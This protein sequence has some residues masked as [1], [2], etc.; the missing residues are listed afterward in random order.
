MHVYYLIQINNY[1]FY[2]NIDVFFYN[3]NKSY[4]D[5]LFAIPKL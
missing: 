5:Y 2:L 1:E 3:Y 4:F